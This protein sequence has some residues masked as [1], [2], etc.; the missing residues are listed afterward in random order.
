MK[1]C[2]RFP[3]VALTVCRDAVSSPRSNIFLSYFDRCFKVDIRSDTSSLSGNIRKW[4]VPQPHPFD[5]SSLVL[6]CSDIDNAE[7]LVIINTAINAPFAVD[8]VSAD[9]TSESEAIAS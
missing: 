6:G 7:V 5:L 2:C 4:F 8:S 9:A 1:L 3:A